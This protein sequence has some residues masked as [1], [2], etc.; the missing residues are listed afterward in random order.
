MCFVGI[1]SL[2]IMGRVVD[3]VFIV[4]YKQLTYMVI[5]LFLTI[6]NECIDFL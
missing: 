1:S 3:L 2:R 5:L 4:V 6:F